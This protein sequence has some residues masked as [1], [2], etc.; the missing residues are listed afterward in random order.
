MRAPFCCGVQADIALE[1]AAVASETIDDLRRRVHREAM[2]VLRSIDDN[3]SRRGCADWQRVIA[4][5]DF[6]G[7]WTGEKVRHLYRSAQREV[8]KVDRSGRSDRSAV[9]HAHGARAARFA[10]L[11]QSP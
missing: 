9:E 10:S 8:G 5:P 1:C 4:R 2:A 11:L 6:D 3:G 7:D